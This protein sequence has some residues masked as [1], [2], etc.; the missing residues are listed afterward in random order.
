MK[1]FVTSWKNMGMWVHYT[2]LAA[3]SDLGTVTILKEACA[4]EERM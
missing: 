1:A 2:E 3:N 4:G